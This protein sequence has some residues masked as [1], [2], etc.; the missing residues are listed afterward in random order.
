MIKS[1][2]DFGKLIAKTAESSPERARRLLLAGFEFYGLKLRLFPEK[3]LPAAKQKSAVYLNKTIRES[4][5]DPKNMA[6]VNVFMPCEILEAMGIVPMCAELFSGFINGTFCERFFAEEAQKEGVAESYCSYHK[7]FLGAAYNGV[8]RA[9]SAIINTSLVCDA[10]NITFK[11]MAS[12]MEIPHFYID[13]PNERSEESVRYVA[14]ELREAAKFLEDATG[15]KLDEEKLKEAVGRS[16]ESIELFKKILDKKRAFCLP[17]DVT[18]EMYEIYL[19]HNGLG[20]KMCLDYAKTYL[21][22]FEGAKRYNGI[23]I[24]WL[25]VMP[26]WQKPVTD[27]FNFSEECRIVACD[28][29]FENFVDTDPEKPYESMARRLVYSYWNSGKSRV[30]RAVEMGKYL[31]VDGVVCFCQWGCKQTLGLTELFKEAFEKEGI[32]LLVLDGD[33]ADRVN[34]SDGQVSTRL[35]AFIETVKGRKDGR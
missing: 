33:G 25:H 29:S 9:P 10:N 19:T 11:E 4:F 16:R 14:E 15:R 35:N 34:T 1:I 26:N 24:L 22:D 5:K 21:R 13:V 7:I 3:R 30:E 18:G 23:K 20:S 12:R 31:G 8:L 17:G 6:L 28:L 27:L 32:P 2:E